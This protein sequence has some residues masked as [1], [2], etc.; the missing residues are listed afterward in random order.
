MKLFL[1]SK[2]FFIMVNVCYVTLLNQNIVPHQMLMVLAVVLVTAQSVPVKGETGSVAGSHDMEGSD[3]LLK[4]FKAIHHKPKVVHH[5]VHKPVPVVRH[6][7][8]KSKGH[9]K[10]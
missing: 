10:G 4:L 5:V 8:Y 6:P 1:V 2:T 9:H 3:S 7:V